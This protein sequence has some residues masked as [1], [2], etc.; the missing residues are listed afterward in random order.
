M[1]DTKIRNGTLKE[2]EMVTE[3][4]RKCFPEA[5]AAKRNAFELRLSNY[6]KTF[7][8]LECE[9]KILSMINGMPTDERD[10]CDQMIIPPLGKRQS[11]TRK[12]V[13]RNKERTNPK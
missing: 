8:V 10:L 11:V 7:W 12:T 3:L 9:G 1:L 5:E 13:V 6:S 4:E 2:L